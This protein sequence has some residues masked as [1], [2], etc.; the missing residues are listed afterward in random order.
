M[1][2]YLAKIQYTDEDDSTYFQYRMTD[3]VGKASR[4]LDAGYDLYLVKDAATALGKPTLRKLTTRVT[5]KSVD[6]IELLDGIDVI[7]STA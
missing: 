6:V 4:M 3:D 7:G 1:S 2:T 5:N